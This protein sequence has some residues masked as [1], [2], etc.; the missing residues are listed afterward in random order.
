[1]VRVG[2]CSWAEKS[3]VQSGEFYPKGVR[4]SEGRLRF[5]AENF[6]TVEV[7]STY[8]A[9]PDISNALL[10][11]SRTPD[12]FVFHV[13]AYGALTG[14][15]I[16]PS[17]LPKDILRTLP[18]ADREK[19]NL[20]VEDKDLQTVI[21]L[22]FARSI[23]P[24]RDAGKLG[25]IIF[26]YPQWFHF[27][28]KNMRHILYARELLHGLPMGVELRHGSWLT[29]ENRDS[30]FAFLRENNITYITADEPQYGSLATVPFVPAVTT[31]TAY[32]RLH[33]RNR[34]NW[35]R[36][37]VETSQRYAYLYSDHELREFIPHIKRAAAE[38]REV[39]FLLNNCH[40]SFAARNALRMKEM[41]ENS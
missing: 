26:Q 18:A 9:I 27:E 1:M 36:K 5:Y 16:N 10:W 2:T 14:H 34:E 31:D 32:F 24:L 21:A 35:L 11:A 25:I 28:R 37:G 4:T 23:E 6:D 15:G 17:T 7:D 41:L 39:Y 30:V 19:S 33:G 38:A 12:N 13:K 22:R 3:L 20:Y 8:Y 29:P 40:G